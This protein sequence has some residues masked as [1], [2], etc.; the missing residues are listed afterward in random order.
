MAK[1]EVPDQTPPWK[2]CSTRG[3]SLFAMAHSC[4]SDG[5]RVKCVYFGALKTD[6]GFIQD[7]SNVESS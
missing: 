6:D 1:S 2:C 7:K 4:D 5:E 3:T